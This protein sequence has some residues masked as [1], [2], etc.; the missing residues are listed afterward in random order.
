MEKACENSPNKDISKK[1]IL[2]KYVA[3][4]W[5]FKLIVINILNKIL[6]LWKYHF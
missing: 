4:Y 5:F 3:Q 2:F 6:L 1:V